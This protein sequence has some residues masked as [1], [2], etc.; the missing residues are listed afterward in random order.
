MSAHVSKPVDMAVLEQAVRKPT[1]ACSDALLIIV[2]LC[3]IIVEEKKGKEKLMKKIMFQGD[4]ITDTGRNTNSG[5]LISIGQGY[6]MIAS[7]YLGAKYP[8]EYE[9]VNRGISGN[10]I[11]DLYARIK[12]DGWNDTPHVLSILIGV[13]DVWHELDWKNGVDSRR[14]RNMYRMLISDTLTECPDT[15]LLIMEPFLLKGSETEKKWDSFFPMV[16]E[17]AAVAREAAQEYGQVFLPLQDVFDRACERAPADWW[18]G[19]G[20]HP[21]PAGHQLIA[22]E[23]IKCF[24]ANFR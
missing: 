22:D 20:V 9:F 11:V 21:N 3:N 23:W 12:G 17:R 5:S 2:D 10:R 7:A 24:E 18:L 6:A 15:R 4:S 19:D 13:N 16:R 8:G 14:F 1:E